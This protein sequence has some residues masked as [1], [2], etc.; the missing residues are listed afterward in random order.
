MAGHLMQEKRA[1]ITHL[2]LADEGNSW[3]PEADIVKDII[4]YLVKNDALQDDE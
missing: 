1:R 3:K 4:D 2:I